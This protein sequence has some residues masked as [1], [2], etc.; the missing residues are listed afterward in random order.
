M[1]RIAILTVSDRGAAGE[2]EDLGGP[3]I[4]ELA[5]GAGHEVVAR[6]VVPDERSL[7]AERL[8][9][10]ADAGTA[11]VIVTTGG[12]GLTPRDVTPE[13]TR[14]VAEREALGIA[15]A[16][17]VNGL[18]HTPFAALTRGLAVTRGRTLIVNLPGNPKAVRQG[19]EVLLP[20][21]DHVAELLAGPVEHGS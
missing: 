5:A 17:V 13:A 11:D 4:A 12:T 3:L 6:G 9:A 15:V 7:I 2:R 10:W 8:R 14:E 16:L 1:A 18:Q 19:M 20:L 21:L